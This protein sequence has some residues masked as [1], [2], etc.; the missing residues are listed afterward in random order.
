MTTPPLPES[1]PA[2]AMDIMEMSPLPH[3]KP[4][5]VVTTEIEVH[6]P[7]PLASPM[8]SPTISAAPSP[9]Q[10]SPMEAPVE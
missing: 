2:P 1:S 9:L 6:S 8:D 3:K 7:S 10:A 4:A 5:Y